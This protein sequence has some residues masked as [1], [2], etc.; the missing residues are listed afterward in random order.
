ML[1][2]RGLSWMAKISGERGLRQQPLLVLI[3]SPI[4]MSSPSPKAK[5][6]TRL[7]TRC[8]DPSAYS[9]LPNQHP[10]V[11]MPLLPHYPT[12][13]PPQPFWPLGQ[14]QMGKMKMIIQTMIGSISLH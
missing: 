4:P 13:P 7:T 3:L 8:L 11:P 10:P 6:P 12:L 9:P 14:I 1:V 5:S 2:W